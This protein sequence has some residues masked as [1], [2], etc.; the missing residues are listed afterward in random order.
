MPEGLLRRSLSIGQGLLDQ[1]LWAVIDEDWHATYSE[2]PYTLIVE[3]AQPPEL[4]MPTGRPQAVPKWREALPSIGDEGVSLRELR[5]SDVPR[6][7]VLLS[8]ARAHEFVAPP[9]PT[10][11]GFERY[12]TWTHRQREA[13]RYVGLGIVPAGEDSAVGLIEI[14]PLDPMFKNAEWGFVIG[15]PYWGTGLFPRA[16]RH[17]LGLVFDVIGVH[18]LEARVAVS[19]DRGNA[20][21]KKLGAT[22]EGQLRRSFLHAGQYVD[23]ALWALLSE[24]RTRSA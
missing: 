2:A 16:A 22:R 6:L 8:E 23:D 7:M 14:R 10:A 5:A 17:A 3:E 4:E 21:L 12:I 15:S 18:R 9:P 24:D 1:I 20:V 13:G 19:N 11:A